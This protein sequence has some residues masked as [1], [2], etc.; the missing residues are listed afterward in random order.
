ME[1]SDWWT[2]LSLL[3]HFCCEKKEA[4]VS[5]VTDI[6]R[7]KVSEMTCGQKCESEKWEVHSCKRFSVKQFDEAELAVTSGVQEKVRAS[8]SFFTLKLSVDVTNRLRTHLPFSLPYS[9]EKYTWARNKSSFTIHISEQIDMI[10]HISP[11][12]SVP[13]VLLGRWN[14]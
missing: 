10:N 3:R 2:E 8:V 5:W 11:Q 4:Q 13:I 9:D 12:S 7:M 6:I 14:T 1:I